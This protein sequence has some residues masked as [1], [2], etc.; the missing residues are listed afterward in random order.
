[1]PQNQ[2]IM[3]SIHSNSVFLGRVRI[4]MWVLGKIKIGPEIL[5]Q[6]MLFISRCQSQLREISQD[7]ALRASS[8]ALPKQ[9]S[10]YTCPYHRPQLIFG[11]REKQSQRHGSYLKAVKRTTAVKTRLIIGLRFEKA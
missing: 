10:L 2:E 7:L 8:L 11:S 3:W 9:V 4:Q 1:M 5:L 6:N